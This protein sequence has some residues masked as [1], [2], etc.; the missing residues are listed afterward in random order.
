MVVPPK[1]SVS[2]QTGSRYS[3]SKTQL[4]ELLKGQRVESAKVAQLPRAR[5]D[6]ITTDMTTDAWYNE[7]YSAN[8]E[9]ESLPFPVPPAV[10]GIPD[11]TMCSRAAYRL[12]QSVDPGCVGV[13]VLNK[14]AG[15]VNTAGLSPLG[16]STSATEQDFLF[17]QFT[18]PTTPISNDPSPVTVQACQNHFSDMINNADL[19]VFPVPPVNGT[20]PRDLLQP[21]SRNGAY[22]FL[23]ASMGVEV[24]TPYQGAA[25]IFAAD[26]NQ[27]PKNWG[28]RGVSSNYYHPGDPIAGTGFFGDMQ[29]VFP[30]SSPGTMRY[31][32]PPALMGGIPAGGG[33]W[34]TYNTFNATVGEFFGAYRSC[35]LPGNSTGAA[36]AQIAGDSD[37]TP[38]CGVIQ[39][40][41]WGYDLMSASG[42]FPVANTLAVLLASGCAIAIINT[43]AVAITVRCT[44]TASW[45]CPVDSSLPEYLNATP[46]PAH[47]VRDMTYLN[48]ANC[49]NESLEAVRKLVKDEMYAKMEDEPDI[50]PRIAA[51]VG[52]SIV[53]RNLPMVVTSASTGKPMT[54]AQSQS[55]LSG[56]WSRLKTAAKEKALS[57]GKDAGRM[58]LQAVASTL[59]I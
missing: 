43:S 7:L 40:N 59:G 8:S 46:S 50:G 3:L 36:Y 38:G 23:G 37:L 47:A 4:Q 52:H 44:C 11:R 48:T 30:G 28:D 51:A 16:L 32:V 41:A 17:W 33:N 13:L 31:L 39:A 25:T 54:Q 45:A 55:L 24:T 1:S 12:T 57:L 2:Q 5:L 58:A 26:T 15:P 6:A 27:N 21:Y 9:C 42:E 22:C 18:T 53:R 14:H 19:A 34:T 49:G 29:Y 20:D 35:T 56:L 10:R